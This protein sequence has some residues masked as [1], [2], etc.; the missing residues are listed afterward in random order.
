MYFLITNHTVH[1][2][3][4]N[5][6]VRKNYFSL[7]ICCEILKLFTYMG[8]SFSHWKKNQDDHTHPVG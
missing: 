1:K 7:L 5:F 3:N 4:M 8:L 2:N 6:N